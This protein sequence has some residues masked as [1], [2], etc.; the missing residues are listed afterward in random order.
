MAKAKKPKKVKTPEPYWNDLV[1]I[2]F[3]FCKEKFH[4]VPS[5]DGSSP[6]DL[7][8]I[9]TVLRK[10]CESSGN[11]WTYEAATGRFKHF[12]EYAYMDRWL[13]DNFI[14]SNISRQKDKIFFNIAKQ[15]LSR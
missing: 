12:L 15:Y 9:I 5:F 7:K 1:G 4:D 8:S 3:S 6:R 13:A 14:L 2:Y 11:E 10:R